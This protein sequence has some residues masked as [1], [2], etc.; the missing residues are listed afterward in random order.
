MVCF[1]ISLG[2]IRTHKKIQV[3][4]T[5]LRGCAGWWRFPI[6]GLERSKLAKTQDRHISLNWPPI[7]KISALSYLQ[8]LKLKKIKCLYFLDWTLFE[9]DMSVMS[10]FGLWGFFGIFLNQ[11]YDHNSPGSTLIM[12]I[13]A[14]LFLQLLKL[15]KIKC[16]Y[17]LGQTPFE[18]NMS[19]LSFSDMW[20][21]FQ[22]L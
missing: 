6:L 19:L 11:Q 7:E 21:A 10:F 18:G 16:L 4:K 22:Y 5:C 15:K 14:L 8:L 3:P 9:G 17:F 1:P 12:K 13:S 2:Q 20:G